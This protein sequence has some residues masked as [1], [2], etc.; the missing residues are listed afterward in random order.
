MVFRTGA[1][2]SSLQGCMRIHRTNCKSSDGIEGVILYPLRHI[3]NFAFASEIRHYIHECIRC[4]IDLKLNVIQS[5]DLVQWQHLTAPLGVVFVVSCA[6]YIGLY[7][8]Q[9]ERF[10]PRCLYLYLSWGKFEEI[11][12][13]Y[14]DQLIL[15]SI[16]DLRGFRVIDA[17]LIRGYAH[18]GTVLLVELEDDL[19][20]FASADSSEEPE[21]S[22][23]G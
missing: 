9:S 11:G 17:V 20:V 23:F 2:I 8:W 18:N 21:P 15:G 6:E 1:L 10:I 13:A 19:V 3:D 5:A 7:V 22:E 14:L 16:Y 4:I 12:L